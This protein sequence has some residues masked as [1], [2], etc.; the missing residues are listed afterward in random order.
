[1]KYLENWYLTQTTQKQLIFDELQLNI[2]QHLDRFITDFNRK[3]ILTSYLVAP[4]YLGVYIYGGVG[5]GKTMLMNQVFNYIT[6]PKKCRMHFHMFMQ[7]VH[8]DLAKYNQQSNPMQMIAKN[9]A[10][11]YK[12]IFLDEMQI[13]DIATA[14]IMQN[15]LTELFKYK[16]YLI[17]SSNFKADD[18]Y[19]G[20]LMAERFL[21]A[22]KLLK[23]KLLNLPLTTSDYRLTNYL[24]NLSQT[25]ENGQSMPNLG[26]S[27][28][29]YILGRKINYLAK[30][31]TSISFEFNIICGNGRSQLD[32]IELIKFYHSFNLINVPKTIDDKELRTR[33]MWLIDVLYDNGCLLNIYPIIKLEKLYNNESGSFNE[34]SRTISR[35]YEMQTIQY[36]QKGTKS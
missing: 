5:S 25:S 7:R 11:N 23:T 32:Y 3:C 8:R 26:Q 9:L 24:T 22:I 1:M 14:M 10:K 15:L 2:I 29:L 21:P 6:N 34:F 33:F 30:N 4:N 36:K 28:D 31:S 19:K 17:T 12:I 20:E 13:S 16:I 27:G 18:L 35:L